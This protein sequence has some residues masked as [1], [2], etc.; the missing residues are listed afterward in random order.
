M[1]SRM[2]PPGTNKI[3]APYLALAIIFSFSCSID[4]TIRGYIGLPLENDTLNSTISFSGLAIADNANQVEVTVLLKNSNGSSIVGSHLNLEIESGD[5]VTVLVPCSDSDTNGRSLCVITAS[6][7]GVKT[8]R[9]SSIT[10]AVILRNSIE[11]VP[12]L[13]VGP[14]YLANKDWNTY[15][16]DAGP[17]LD[18]YSQLDVT[19]DG[20]ET[21]PYTCIHGGEKRKVTVTGQSSC[22]E[23]NL[24]ELL[25]AFDWE[26]KVK[27]GVATFFTKALKSSQGLKNL[28]S[29]SAWKTN[30]V[31]VYKGAK[32]VG[33]SLPA[34]WDWTNTIE[35][36]P[37]NVGGAYIT[38]D[39]TDDDGAGPDSVYSVGTI[40]TLSSSRMTAGYRFGLDG[41]A[42]VTLPGA[43]LSWDGS[44]T[45]NCGVYI[46][47]IW[48]SGTEPD[49]LW[50]EGEFNGYH[51]N[52]SARQLIR[53]WGSSMSQVKS[54]VLKN[55]TGEGTYFRYGSLN[56]IRDLVAVG[57]GGAI[58]TGNWGS[59]ANLDVLGGT[60]V[61]ID[62][63]A[64][65][66][67]YNVRVHNNSS[68]GLAVGDGATAQ[69][70]VLSNNHNVGL[71]LD[72]LNG[73]AVGVLSHNNAAAGI[74]F[75]SGGESRGTAT[76]VTSIN[77]AW[78]FNIRSDGD[79][80]TL[81]N[82]VILNEGISLDGIGNKFSNLAFSDSLTTY[83][84]T[85]DNSFHQNLLVASGTQCASSLGTN[86]GLTSGTCEP[87]GASTHVVRSGLVLTASMNS[88]LSLDDP[89]N[90]SDTLGVATYSSDLDWLNFLNPLRGWGR[91]GL[92]PFPDPSHQGS[93]NG[94][95]PNCVIWDFSLKTADSVLKNTSGAGNSSL[96]NQAFIQGQTCPTAVHGNRAISDSQQ[97][98][99]YPYIN[100]FEDNLAAGGNDNGI[101]ESGEKCY[102]QFLVNAIEIYGDRVGDEDG[103]C[104]N[105]EA[106]IYS[107][108]F[109]VDQGLG[110]IDSSGTCVFQNG[111]VQDVL[112][113]RRI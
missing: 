36:L 33:Q 76:H 73:T 48:N 79:Y 44:S 69:K 72:G 17:S 43:E 74:N 5:G 58:G 37:A 22:L 78:A 71:Q 101:C 81:A 59:A 51:A 94:S 41:M 53:P 26:C 61:G 32:L 112:L 4:N 31:S 38:L 103:L 9:V 90:T 104:E 46:C 110:E 13:T 86:Q 7:P 93:C 98:D 49:R 21:G 82:G 39:G 70:V 100:A 3:F 83:A 62:A 84:T 29:A 66:Y 19:C 88:K 23:L 20:S 80:M 30:S 108:N 113:Y 91:D 97:R 99:Y 10:P 25:G 75:R 64:N 24:V 11:F 95:S 89:V 50:I 1:D 60:G 15:V 14:V 63:G 105:G 96:E 6:A 2:L 67:L 40:F 109:G 102:N 34:I 85:V 52:Q 56:R 47:M 107:P 68:T 55:G 54:T 111:L 28:I 45:A 77:N 12:L 42:I 65:S 106:C 92:V 87:M 35:P 27:L 57:L 18:E 8:I 16:K